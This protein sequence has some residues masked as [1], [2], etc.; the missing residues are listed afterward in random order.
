M[1]AFALLTRTPHAV[2][3]DF[4][5]DSADGF[6]V[7]VFID[8]ASYDVTE[9][10]ALYPTITFVKIE[11]DICVAAGYTKSSYTVCKDGPTSWDKAL[12]YFG[13]EKRAVHEHVWF[14]EDDTFFYSFDVIRAMDTARPTTDVL[15]KCGGL[16]TCKEDI[17]RV[18][19]HWAESSWWDRPL[20]W[21]WAFLC[22]CRMSTAVLEA[23]C[24]FATTHGRLAFIECLIPTLAHAG[25]LSVNYPFQLTSIDVKKETSG[26]DSFNAYHPVKDVARHASIREYL[27]SGPQHGRTD[28]RPQIRLHMLALPHTITSDEYSHCAFTGKVKRFAPMMRSVGDEVFHYG[29]EGSETGASRDIEVLK[30]DEWNLLRLASYKGLHPDM[31]VADCEAALA[32]PASF[33]GDL[34]NLNTILYKVFNERLRP[35]LKQHYRSDITDIV[36]LPFGR[37]H[38]FAL[39]GLNPVAV[40]SGI[41]Y[42]DSYRGYRVFESYAY[43]HHQLGNSKEGPQNYW[44]VVPNYFNST[45]WPLCLSPK[46]DTVGF[47]GRLNSIK[48]C[49]EVA[50]IAA[51][52]PHLRFVICGQGDPTPFL[53]EPNIFY[54][55]P[56]HGD[57]RG[58]Y[59]GSLVACVAPSRFTEPFCGVAVEAQLCGTPVIT[60]HCGAQTE[61]VEQGVTGL[62]CHTLH[63]YV[64][65]VT[66][67]TKGLFNRTYIRDRAVKLYDM[68]N[69]AREYDYVFKCI[70]D[71]HNGRTGW[72]A[73]S[74]NFEHLLAP[75]AST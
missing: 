46:V 49:F 65:G 54:K 71:V 7:Y 67:A 60:T 51:R 18:P 55:A 20:P 22:L 3:L 73:T 26:F 48:G 63:D 27:A 70:N 56:L 1:N 15:I 29:R 25:G 37:T 9:I 57:E 75:H 16:A 39:E 35:L 47:L 19:W 41:G 36:C 14:C 17:A 10:T 33:I 74:S 32:A 28:D 11:N 4:L 6:A 59:L 8:D 64:V 24:E 66:M 30:R 5:K 69:V 31:S 62:L 38:D 50:S 42:P 44:F 40:E 61:T 34:G 43:L 23:I 53:T 58:E 68:Y 45:S 12:F 52:M 2:W 13:T 21:H 72:T